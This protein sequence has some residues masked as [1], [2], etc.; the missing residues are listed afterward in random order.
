[1]KSNER[2][3]RSW[4]RSEVRL[5]LAEARQL[6][7]ERKMQPAVDRLERTLSLIDH[8]EKINPGPD[9]IAERARVETERG[10]ALATNIFQR[11]KAKEALTRAAESLTRLDIDP[12][13]YGVHA[14]DLGH[15]AYLLAAGLRNVNLTGKAIPVAQL[16]AK[17]Q[18][19]VLALAPQS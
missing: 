9:L 4:L 3:T 1:Q 18:R 7:G 19:Q 5:A 15:T 13:P 16:G 12:L 8:A 10:V 14:R 6:L 17:W 11:S 2:I